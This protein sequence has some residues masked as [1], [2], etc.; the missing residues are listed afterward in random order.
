[1]AVHAACNHAWREAGD[2]SHHV[3][4][5][6]SVAAA[7]GQK[8]T[9]SCLLPLACVSFCRGLIWW[10]FVAHHH[11]VAVILFFFKKDFEDFYFIGPSVCANLA[12][13]Q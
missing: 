5:T 10:R 4:K 3:S 8:K 6:G 2:A 1:M 12:G 11:H 7:T 13:G 9:D